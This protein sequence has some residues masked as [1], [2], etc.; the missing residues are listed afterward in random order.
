VRASLLEE[1]EVLHLW[2]RLEEGEIEA[3]VDLEVDEMDDE[4]DDAQDGDP[5]LSI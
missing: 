4:Y 2:V 5:D 1:G 3:D